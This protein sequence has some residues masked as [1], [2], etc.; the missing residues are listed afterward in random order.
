[1]PWK[2]PGRQE[3]R[4][5]GEVGRLQSGKKKQGRDPDG[6]EQKGTGGQ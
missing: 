4:H 3:G 6:P 5:Q 2:G 1:M